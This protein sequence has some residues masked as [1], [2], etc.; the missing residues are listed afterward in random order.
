MR[1]HA[2]NARARRLYCVYSV[3]LLLSKVEEFVARGSHTNA[4][5][6]TTMTANPDTSALKRSAKLIDATVFD[7]FKT[8][9]NESEAERLG[10]SLQLL[11]HLER[12]QHDTEKVTE[13]IPEN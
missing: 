13:Q 9:T 5:I 10:G 4:S 11:H 6:H 7:A 2:S 8:L 1:T 12:Q 3:R